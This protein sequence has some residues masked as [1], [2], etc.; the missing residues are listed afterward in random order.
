MV[1]AGC[2][3]CAEQRGR[4]KSVNRSGVAQ[5]DLDVACSTVVCLPPFELAVL[6]SALGARPVVHLFVA[7]CAGDR[8]GQVELHTASAHAT[9]FRGPNGTGVAKLQLQ[10]AIKIN[11]LKTVI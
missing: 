1:L 8:S 4:E 3:G 5:V 7:E 10:L 2:A 11:K 6:C 9:S